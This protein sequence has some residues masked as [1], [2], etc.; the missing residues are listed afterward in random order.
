MEIYDDMD[1]ERPD[2]IATRQQQDFDDLQR[3][4]AGLDV[5]RVGRF[6]PED[7]RNPEQSEKGKAARQAEMVTRLQ[8]MM[9]DPA[10]A[11]L[12]NDTT[13]RLREAQ[14]DLDRMREQA[15]QILNEEDGAIA[16]LEA[17]AARDSEGRSV[18]KD[19]GGDVRYADGASV[20]A[21]EAAGIVWR[22]DEPGFEERHARGER[23]AEAEK[24]LADIDAEQAEIGDMQERLE[25][26][27]DPASADDLIAMGERADD[28]LA[29]LDAELE[30][31]S[32]PSTNDIGRDASLV[33]AMTPGMGGP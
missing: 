19:Q 2:R 8:M 23:R 29:G 27:N 9:R 33:N 18:F 1:I 5:G 32:A 6:L 24:I 28:L 12:H 13:K 30:A 15:Q 17:R 11:A 25:S 4:V 16:R 21:D 10:Y 7:M 3:E 22:G 31:L 20:P 26:D 14:N